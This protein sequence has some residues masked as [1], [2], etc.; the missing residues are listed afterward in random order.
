MDNLIGLGFSIIAIIIALTFHEAAHAWMANKLGDPTA[1][2]Q[3]RVSL[4]PLVHLDF[5]GTILIFIIGIG[6]GKPVP[7]DDRNFQNPRRDTTLVAAAGPF[8]NLIIA[9]ICT[10]ALQYLPAGNLLQ[11]FLT[12]SLSL[13]LTLIALNLLPIPPLDGSK[14]LS[15]FIPKRYYYR[16]QEFINANLVYILIFFLFDSQFGPKIY[17]DSLISLYLSTASDFLGGLLWF[18]T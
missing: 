2:L 7:V 12:I 13:N 4:N 6:W 10:I 3:G 15:I 8:A 18:T 14:I 5:L 17:G 1:R 11:L 16:Y 9:I